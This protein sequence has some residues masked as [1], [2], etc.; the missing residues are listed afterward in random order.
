MCWYIGECYPNGRFLSFRQYC[1]LTRFT[2]IQIDVNDE[3]PKYLCSQCCSDLE[4]SYKFKIRCEYTDRKFRDAIENGQN[5]QDDEGRITIR[6]IKVEPV[7]STDWVEYNF[8]VCSNDD[9]AVEVSESNKDIKDEEIPSEYLEDYVDEEIL[10]IEPFNVPEKGAFN[11]AV[12]ETITDGEAT[13]VKGAD[14][15]VMHTIDAEL[16]QD[17]M[18]LSNSDP[19][20]TKN[21]TNLSDVF[22]KA[23]ASCR[24]AKKIF[25][26]DTCEATFTDYLEFHQHNRTHGRERYQCNV[27]EKWFSKRY[28]LK[29]HMAIHTMEKSFL[30]TL[31]PNKY[32]N[33][34]NLDRHIRVFHK[35]E[36]RYECTECG[37][38]FSQTTILRQHMTIH[39]DERNFAC[40]ICGKKFKAESYMLLH[41]NRHL[42]SA[43]RRKPSRRSTSAAPKPPPKTCV[44]TE[45]GKRFNSTTLFMSHKR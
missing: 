2:F 45:C 31:C 27:C 43:V 18:D 29:N 3:L 9:E 7:V 10:E 19:N 39:T 20:S 40:E 6:T 33:Q 38:S 1:R 35:K 37:K 15:A 26:C 16:N 22:S 41:R 34:G 5:M 11:R 44:C 21:S 32:T 4:Y 24:R 36:K 23:V 12:M 14:S 17:Q 13:T 8:D 30:C 42:P 25:Q 28:H